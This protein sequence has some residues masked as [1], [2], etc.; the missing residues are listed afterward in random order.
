MG[1]LPKWCRIVS[2]SWAMWAGINL[3]TH[4][5]G[6]K[7][8]GPQHSSVSPAHRILLWNYDSTNQLCKLTSADH[9]WP[10]NTRN[11]EK[12]GDA[13]LHMCVWEWGTPKVMVIVVVEGK[14]SLTIY[15]L[16]SIIFQSSG[17][18]QV[19]FWPRHGPAK[20]AAV[21]LDTSRILK[22]LW[23]QQTTTQDFGIWWPS[24]I[25]QNL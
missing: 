9:P 10:Q 14:H 11:K 16:L 23:L 22:E 19:M 15:F 17:F 6:L 24:K 25:I 4:S 5:N 8:N 18:G 1:F 2:I 13:R 7:G 21:N 3:P 20:S 12:L